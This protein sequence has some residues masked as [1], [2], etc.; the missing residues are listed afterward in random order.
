MPPVLATI[1]LLAF[2]AATLPF[3]E[4]GPPTTAADSTSMSS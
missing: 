1:S 4:A 3:R 2:S